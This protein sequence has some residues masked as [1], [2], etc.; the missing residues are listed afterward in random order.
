[1]LLFCRDGILRE[2]IFKRDLVDGKFGDGYYYDI[3]L[4]TMETILSNRFLSHLSSCVEFEPGLTLREFMSN[5]MPWAELVQAITKTDITKYF[6]A[7]SPPSKQIYDRLIIRTVIEFSAIT[8]IEPVDA[9]IEAY[10]DTCGYWV[11][12]NPIIT[13]KYQTGIHV[14][15]YGQKNDVNDRFSCMMVPVSQIADVPLVIGDAIVTDRNERS[16]HLTNPSVINPSNPLVNVYK[17]TDGKSL[18]GIHA[19]HTPSMIDLLTGIISGIG[20]HGD[21]EDTELVRD[22]IETSLKECMEHRDDASYFT[23]V[24]SLDEFK[25]LPDVKPIRN[26]RETRFDEDDEMRY[27]REL[28]ELASLRCDVRKRREEG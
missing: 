25:A 24:I 5:L 7:M 12:G 2:T 17:G 11:L 28:I 26:R 16:N 1:M 20:F 23:T 6:A 4:T 22:D 19:S 8:K 14:E 13:D 15:C 18:Y 10:A 27:T 9:E 21:P 3:P